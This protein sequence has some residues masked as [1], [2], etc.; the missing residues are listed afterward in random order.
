MSQPIYHTIMFSYQGNEFFSDCLIHRRLSL[1][2]LTR[3]LNRIIFDNQYL[4][5]PLM[6]LEICI[7]HDPVLKQAVYDHRHH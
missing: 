5:E 3:I 4:D 7:N 1:E 2:D 6:N